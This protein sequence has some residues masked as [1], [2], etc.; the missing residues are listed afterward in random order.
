MFIW[1]GEK[2]MKKYEGYDC[3]DLSIAYVCESL[4]QEYRGM[5]LGS[6]G[7]GFS[8]QGELIGEKIILERTER[9]GLLK[10][11]HGISSK[12]YVNENIPLDI[13]QKLN[14]VCEYRGRWEDIKGHIKKNCLMDIDTFGCRWDKGY[15][16][17]HGTHSCIVEHIEGGLYTIWDSWYEVRYIISEKELEQII[18]R[19]IILES[20]ITEESELITELRNMLETKKEMIGDMIKLKDS[21][22]KVNLENEFKGCTKTTYF[23]APLDSKMLHLQEQ[24]MQSYHFYKYLSEKYQN[25]YFYHIAIKFM[26]ISKMWTGLKGEIVM[27]YLKKETTC[28]DKLSKM[29]GN[30]IYEED[31][32]LKE[33]NTYLKKEYKI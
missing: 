15:K 14:P 7:L 27:A 29:L 33:L 21:L 12:Q 8:S 30:I 4:K 11:I 10:K 17:Y 23:H 26:N 5:F 19:V 2:T 13:Y 28:G 16:K 22:K 31:L 20:D 18:Q 3:V 24:R 25:K 1:N 6:W 9:F 32:L